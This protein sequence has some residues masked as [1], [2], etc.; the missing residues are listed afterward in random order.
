M[1]LI[2]LVATYQDLNFC[3]VFRVHL[4]P[5]STRA[6]LVLSVTK[7]ILH[8]LT[9]VNHVHVASTVLKAPPLLR[10]IASQG[11]G[12]RWGRR[13]EIRTHVM[14]ARTII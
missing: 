14:L 6:R 4:Q 5:P 7:L 13:L 8:E 3:A 10:A 11:I 9:S 1:H 2:K 12:A